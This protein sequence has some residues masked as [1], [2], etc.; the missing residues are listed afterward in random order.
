MLQQHAAERIHR[1]EDAHTNWYLVEDGPHSGLT[2]VDTGLP[3]SWASLQAAL[4]ELGRST[5]DIEAVVLTHGHFDHMGFARRAQQELGV[6]IWA[7]ADELSVV[8]H[9]W[10]Y[11]HERSRLPYFRHPEFVKIFTEMTGMGAL[12]VRG[13]DSAHAYGPHDRLDVPGSPQVVFTPGHTRGHCSLLFADRGAV[14]AGDAFVTLDPYTGREGPCVV[15]GAAT[16]DS[17]QAL[18]SLGAL[19]RLDATTALTG[20]GPP[21]KGPMSEAVERAQAAG[22]A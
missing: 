5:A 20:H 16:A 17:D 2:V 19:A 15:A 8:S 18:S 9:P 13:S 14:I 10:R 12:W 11:D 3:R 22:A 4:G 7:H 1:I 6:P 21:W